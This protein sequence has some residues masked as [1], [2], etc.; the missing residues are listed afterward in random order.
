MAMK[1]CSSINL[2]HKKVFNDF[3]RVE[4]GVRREERKP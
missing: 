1:R 3:W 4:I 2:V